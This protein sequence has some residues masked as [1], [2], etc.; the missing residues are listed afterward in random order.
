MITIKIERNI[1]TVDVN[2]HIFLLDTV[3]LYHFLLSQN[4]FT[5][6]ILKDVIEAFKL[7]IRSFLGSK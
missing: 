3:T 7:L 1:T 4:K 5:K 6:V 2:L